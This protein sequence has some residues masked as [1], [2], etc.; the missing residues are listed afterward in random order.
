MSTTQERDRAALEMIREELERIFGDSLGN[1][2]PTF[3]AEIIR[4]IDAERVEF[5]EQMHWLQVFAKNIA[6]AQE[7]YRS[8]VAMHERDSSPLKTVPRSTRRKKW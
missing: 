2:P 7:C 6:G 8:N 3:Y 1:A 4:R 5:R